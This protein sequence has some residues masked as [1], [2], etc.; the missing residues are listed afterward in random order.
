[1]AKRQPDYL[2]KSTFRFRDN[3]FDPENKRLEQRYVQLSKKNKLIDPQ[4]G[5]AYDE[6]YDPSGFTDPKAKDDKG[7][8]AEGYFRALDVDP[9]QGGEQAR[10]E[11]MW[12]DANKDTGTNRGSERFAKV[13]VPG[14]DDLFRYAK[15]KRYV[16]HSD[17]FS[18]AGGGKS[19]TTY[20]HKGYDKEWDKYNAAVMAQRHHVS[21]STRAAK[22]ATGK[23][24][25]SSFIVGT[26]SALGE[27]GVSRVKSGQGAEA[28]TN[29]AAALRGQRRRIA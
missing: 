19:R 15:I 29:Q 24:G 26:E 18:E 14:R 27:G 5:T 25:Q 23:Q 3:A 10:L 4:T 28:K 9:E 2:R 21:A 17:L 13:P 8:S 1:M 22:A 20:A 6:K 11:Y 12:N 7:R 16:N